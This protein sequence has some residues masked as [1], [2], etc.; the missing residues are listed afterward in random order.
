[1]PAVTPITTPVTL[2]VMAIVPGIL[3]HT[4]PAVGSLIAVVSPTHKL[5]EPL[6]GNG[7]GFTV[8]I[9]VAAQPDTV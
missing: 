4:P 2:S 1:M 9:A 5:P 3:L 8:T 6:T 7:N